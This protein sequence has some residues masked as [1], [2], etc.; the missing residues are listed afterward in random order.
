MEFETKAL[1]RKVSE[2]RHKGLFFIT[3]ALSPIVDLAA[4]H[5]LVKSPHGPC[6]RFFLLQKKAKSV[7]MTESSTV[8]RYLLEV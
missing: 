4:P 8:H 3:A 1:L 5:S 6:R 2:D 7:S